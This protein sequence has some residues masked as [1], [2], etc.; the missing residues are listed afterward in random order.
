MSNRRFNLQF[1]FS[2]IE[3]LI[4]LAIG[5]IASLVIVNVF[6]VFES[7][8]RTT[9]G[10]S[11]AQTNGSIALYNL[12]RDMQLAGFGLP[13]YGE[14]YSPFSCPVSGTGSPTIDHD[15]SAATPTIGIF[16][17]VIN[18]GTGASGSDVISIRAGDT[19][20]GGIGV[21][22][23][24]GTSTN[25]AQVDNHIG[26]AVGDV[27][28]II[29]TVN[30]ECNMARVSALT[31]VGATPVRISF[32]ASTPNIA[33]G[34]AVACLGVWNEFRYS[35]DANNQLTRSGAVVAGVPSSTAVPIVTDI[36]NLQAQYGVSA[37]PDSNQI[38]QW[39]NATGTWANPTLDNRNRIKAVRV[40]IVARNGS[41]QPNNVTAACSSLTAPNP[42]GLCA[43]DGSITG[44]AAPA[45]DLSADANWQ[46]YRY[47]VYQS[48]IPIRNIIWS[49]SKF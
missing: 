28:L 11:D 25:N 35:V 27:A 31:A 37:A 30:R 17:V 49:G 43:W 39:V 15:N 8:K 10:S 1:G 34:N 46:R 42:T 29:N 45:I 12:Q 24:A 22:M 3:V 13:V 33:S 16:P 9:T 47:R 4:G 21:N 23:V 5:L 44:S 19:M 32:P 2:L 41:I 18:N 40:A 38:T 14:E 7:Q 6:S 48:I 26:C 36:V 20:R